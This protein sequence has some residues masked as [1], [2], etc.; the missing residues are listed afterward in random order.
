MLE[1]NVTNLKKGAV[2]ALPWMLDEM[3]KAVQLAEKGAIKP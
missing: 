1:D 3:E 2:R